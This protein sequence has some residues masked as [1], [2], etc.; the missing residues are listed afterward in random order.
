M[1]STYDDFPPRASLPFHPNAS[2]RAHTPLFNQNFTPRFLYR[3]V[4]PQ[5]VTTSAPSPIIPHAPPD[6]TQ[7]I[8]DLP[9]PKAAAV[10]LKHLLWQRGHEDGCNLMSWTS[11]LLFALQYA[12]YRHSKVG[13]DLGQIYLIILDTNAFPPG[14]FIQ[15]ME[16]MRA[17]QDSDI[18]LQKFVEFR[19]SEYYFGEYLTQGG[20]DIKGQCTFTSVQLI[21]QLGLFDLQPAL[22]E[23][24][25]WSCWPKRVLDFRRLFE[26]QKAVPTT[27]GDIEVAVDIARHC[28]GGKWVVPATIML[29]ALQPR[30]RDDRAIVQGFKERFTEVRHTGLHRMRVDTQRLPEVRQFKWLVELIQHSYELYDYQS[31][32]D[33]VQDLK[34]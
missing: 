9:S 22:A 29:L 28:F 2:H 20:L 7:D 1:P 30:N 23:Q 25:Q 14:T 24:S 13:N 10:L 4:A 26:D 19:E 8:F 12:L 33:S 15:D 32:V 18:K 16:V 6:N 27:D 21:I 11:S 3:L 34:V 17:F 5:Y 31:L